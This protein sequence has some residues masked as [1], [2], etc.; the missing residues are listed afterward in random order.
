M[1]L[2]KLNVVLLALVGREKA[3]ATSVNVILQRVCM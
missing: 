2:L 3:A 1:I